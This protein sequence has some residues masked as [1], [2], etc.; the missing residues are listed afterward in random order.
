MGEGGIEKNISD[1][2]V[3][4]FFVVVWDG[5]WEETAQKIRDEDQ[6]CCRQQQADLTPL[7]LTSDD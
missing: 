3:H 2:V 5:R 7:F 1:A 6:E 4:F